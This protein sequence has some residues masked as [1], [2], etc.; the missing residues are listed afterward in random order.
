MKNGIV[1]WFD[2]QKALDSFKQRKE[3][4]YSYTFHKSI[5][6]DSK[7]LEEG[8]EVTFKKWIEGQKAPK[9][10]KLLLLDKETANLRAV[11]K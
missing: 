10:Q 8:E 5:K 6:Q 11:S 9:Q 2:S 4:M 7:P 1:K 3:R